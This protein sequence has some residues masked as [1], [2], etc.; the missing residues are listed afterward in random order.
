[1]ARGNELEL[2]S[3]MVFG[4]M[5]DVI[6]RKLIIL[7][8]RYSKSPYESEDMYPQCPSK[9]KFHSHKTYR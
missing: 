3:A 9:F 1:M 7:F 2:D 5:S 4:Y 8:G 6:P